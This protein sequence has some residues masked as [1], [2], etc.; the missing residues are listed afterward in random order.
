LLLAAWVRGL[1][2]QWG[3]VYDGRHRWL[4]CEPVHGRASK[5][6]DPGLGPECRRW[7]GAVPSVAA[8]APGL[9]WLRCEAVHGRASKPGDPGLEPECRRWPGAVPSVAASAP[10]LRWL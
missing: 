6:G 8:S 5:P 7:S 10:G 4:R 3:C 1:R 9:R 2:S